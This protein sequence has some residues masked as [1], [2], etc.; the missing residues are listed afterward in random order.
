ME[1]TN[2]MWHIKVSLVERGVA[3]FAFQSQKKQ[4]DTF[5]LIKRGIDSGRPID[6]E[7]TILN[8]FYVMSVELA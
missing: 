2:E 8:P 4:L 6:I 1:T 5:Q 7:G 3:L